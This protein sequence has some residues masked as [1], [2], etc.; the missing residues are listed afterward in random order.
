VVRELGFQR[1]GP[2]IR[3]TVLAAVRASRQGWA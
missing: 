3:E 1:K 2:R